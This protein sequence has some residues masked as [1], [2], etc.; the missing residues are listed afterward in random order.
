VRIADTIKPA[1]DYV[2][3]ITLRDLLPLI[4]IGLIFYYSLS[5]HLV[6]NR[7]HSSKV[8]ASNPTSNA[9]LSQQEA[10]YQAAFFFWIGVTRN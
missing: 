8:Y 4:L 1:L 3:V 7:R 5:L 10:L 9:H 2:P 6:N